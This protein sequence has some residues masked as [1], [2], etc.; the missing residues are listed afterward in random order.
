MTER[1]PRQLSLIVSARSYEALDGTKM[2]RILDRSAAETKVNYYIEALLIS[3]HKLW[4]TT[5]V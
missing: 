3:T 5:T 4:F 2:R 1:H